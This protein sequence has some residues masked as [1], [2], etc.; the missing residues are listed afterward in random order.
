MTSSLKLLE[1]VQVGKE[2]VKGTAV[3]ATRRLIGDFRYRRIQDVYEFLDQNS[4]VFARVP[5]QGVVTR[6]ASQ[7]EG[8]GPLDYQQILLPLL[9]GMKGGVTG[10]GAGA[11]KLWT[12]DPSTS[13]PPALD[14]YTVEY[15]ERSP[16]DNAEMEFAYGIT[17]EIEITASTDNMTEM[18]YRMFGR[19]SADSTMT[20]ALAVPTNLILDAPVRWGVFV[21][22]TFAGI[23]A[24]QILAQVYGF[25]WTYKGAVHPG[26]YLDNRSTLDFATEEYGRP[27]CEL[28]LDVVHDPLSTA[29]VQTQEA[30]K[31][32]QTLQYIECRQTGATLGTS[33]YLVKLQGAYYHMAD[34]MEERGN[35]RDGN[36]IVRMHFGSAYDV[37]S[38]FHVKAIIT[39]QIATFP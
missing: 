15:T 36:Q 25:R 12:F 17:D 38:G 31:T 21:D 26:F 7:L 14:A 23:G 30:F 5:R 16:N 33:T 29:F 18:R 9:S 34:S 19:A 22:T 8:R 10:V 20:A 37:T 35:D 6:H 24:T 11:D 13:V 27:E 32:A 39:N 1:T 2:T 4:G 28:E 3:A